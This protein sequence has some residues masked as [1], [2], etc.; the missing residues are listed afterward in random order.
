MLSS[1]EVNSLDFQVTSLIPLYM[2]GFCFRKLLEISVK[3]WRLRRHC[4]S[5]TLP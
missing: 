5:E 3:A 2:I 4:L 1:G